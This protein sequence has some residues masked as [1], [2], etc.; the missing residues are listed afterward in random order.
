MRRAQPWLGTLVDISIAEDEHES[1]L[2]AAIDSAFAEVALAHRLMSFHESGSDIQRINLAR[3][4]QSLTVHPHTWKVLVVAEQ[5]RRDSE[6][7]FN[8]ACAARLVAWGI[9]P[10]P[11]PELPDLNAGSPI[12]LE[13]AHCVRKLAPG[14]IDVGGI[15]K[16]YAVDLAIESLRQAGIGHACV[17]AG[18]DLRAY[19]RETIVS[20][21]APDA[22]TR[23]RAQVKLQDEALA[24]SAPSF[25]ARRARGQPVSALCDARSGKPMVAAQSVSVLAA[26]CMMADALTKVALAT[27]NICDPLLARYGASAFFLTA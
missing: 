23:I 22:P 21:R 6:G 26:S 14:W 4:G 20:L 17:N 15:A 18:G 19:G 5:L 9:L 1:R 13:D 2:H 16:G 10:R 8:I 27:E 24:S 25:S 7:I 11:H 3:P 12:Q